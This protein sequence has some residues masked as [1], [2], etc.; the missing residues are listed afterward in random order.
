MSGAAY[1]VYNPDAAAEHLR[2]ETV[3]AEP[4]PRV[5][6][7]HDE[8]IFTFEYV[9]D[10]GRIVRPD[11]GIAQRR[12]EPAE[13]RGARKESPGLGRLAAEYLLGQEVDDKSIV[14]SEF[15]DEHVR[16]RVPS[17]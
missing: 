8:E 15:A 12:A 17:Q 3:I 1:C 5:I 7:R 10:L 13:N 11:N 9:D 6:K 16:R 2:E 4:L 14:A